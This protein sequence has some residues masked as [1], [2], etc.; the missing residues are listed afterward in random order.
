LHLLVESKK[1]AI[2]VE[3]V[4]DYVSRVMTS[5][6]KR[7]PDG[8]EPPM[9]EYSFRFDLSKAIQAVAFLLKQT[10]NNAKNYTWL[11]KLLYVAD[12]ESIKESG[13]PIT[14]DEPHAM[15]SGPV[16][17]RIYDHIKGEEK[18]EWQKYFGREGYDIKLQE[19]PGEGDLCPYEMEKLK[20]LWERHKEKSL[21]E[22]IDLTHQ[23]KEY[24]RNEPS[25]NT[26]TP[27]PLSDILDRVD[28]SDQ[29]G[30]IVENAENTHE[31]ERLIGPRK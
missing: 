5:P 3:R 28:L 13:Y 9:S 14:G 29:E 10:E 20:E 11:L 8:G 16:L 25:C 23:F 22:M 1:F 15:E 24:K 21:G 31:L 30:A 4:Y 26:S 6:F 12:V 19:D 18:D 7:S 2:N 17:S 27:I